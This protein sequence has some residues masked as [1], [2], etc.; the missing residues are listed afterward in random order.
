MKRLPPHT[1]ASKQPLP[2]LRLGLHRDRSHAYAE[3]R[4]I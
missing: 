4:D 1:R 2:F 3:I